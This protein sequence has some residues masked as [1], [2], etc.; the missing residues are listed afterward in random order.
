MP[1]LCNHLCCTLCVCC[2]FQ[3]YPKFKSVK[4]NFRFAQMEIKWDSKT[5]RANWERRAELC[6]NFTTLR[7]LCGHV[8]NG[9]RRLFHFEF[10]Q[11]PQLKQHKKTIFVVKWFKWRTVKRL[12]P[13]TRRMKK[14]VGA[15]EWNEFLKKSG[16]RNASRHKKR[17]VM[18]MESIGGSC[19]V[20]SNKRE[21]ICYDVVPCSVT[22]EYGECATKE[23][24]VNNVQWTC[25]KKARE[26]KPKVSQGLT[27]LVIQKQTT[28]KERERERSKRIRRKNGVD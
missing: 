21:S 23:R 9:D 6:V 1:G 7:T 4:L 5:W 20:K 11:R 22:H 19:Q 2:P 10:A 12:Q 13:K 18:W 25:I 8:R 24:T 15:N 27:R 28:D 14:S 3:C 26:L 16:I 17:W